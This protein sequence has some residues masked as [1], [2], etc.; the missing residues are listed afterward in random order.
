MSKTKQEWERIR[1]RDAALC[2]ETGIPE[3]V[4]RVREIGSR[5]R[6]AGVYH[7][8]PDY[9]GSQG[10]VD[11]AEFEVGRTLTYDEFHA[12]QSELVGA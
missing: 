7:C 2:D 12:L 4:Q 6:A 1:A 10:D 11:F 5:C 9:L 3:N 8:G